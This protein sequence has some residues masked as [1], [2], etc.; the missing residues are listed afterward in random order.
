[1]SD[2]AVR[3]RARFSASA[4]VPQSRDLSTDGPEWRSWYGTILTG[5]GTTLHAFRNSLTTLGQ[6]ELQRG[7][8]GRLPVL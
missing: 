1:M 5:S 6:A 8:S 3:P 4:W 2:L 7:A